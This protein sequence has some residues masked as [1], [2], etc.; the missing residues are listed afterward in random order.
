M[1]K[2]GGDDGSLRHSHK[3]AGLGRKIMRFQQ[4]PAGFRFDSWCS[5]VFIHGI[6]GKASRS[7]SSHN[8]TLSIH[9]HDYFSDPQHA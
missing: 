9:S 2:T 8:A 7:L 3:Q 4:S 6:S 1:V 5:V